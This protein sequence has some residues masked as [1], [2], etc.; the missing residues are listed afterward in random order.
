MIIM[1][2]LSSGARVLRLHRPCCPQGRPRGS[3]FQNFTRIS[4]DSS[5]FHKNSARTS[6][7][8]TF[9]KRIDRNSA[10]P[11]TP[12]P[13]RSPPLRCSSAS[14]RGPARPPH[15]GASCVHLQH[16]YYY[17]SSLLV[18]SLLLLLVLVLLLSLVVVVLVGVEV[19]SVARSGRAGD[20]RLRPDFLLLLWGGRSRSDKCD[21]E[22]VHIGHLR[23]RMLAIQRACPRSMMEMWPFSLLP[24][25]SMLVVMCL[26][27]YAKSGICLTHLFT[28]HLLAFN[29]DIWGR[30]V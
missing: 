4:Q 21:F 19:R 11:H 20:M 14:W 29:I 7:R 24:K 27:V 2:A 26:R 1:L 18:L 15:P 30:G 8:S 9:K 10:F 12:E 6:N 5:E 22:S 25:T 3:P 28:P 23:H 17:S 13:A 16:A